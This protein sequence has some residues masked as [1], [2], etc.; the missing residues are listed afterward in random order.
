MKPLQGRSIYDPKVILDAVQ[1]LNRRDGSAN[2]SSDV[3][4]VGG[5]MLNCERGLGSEGETDEVGEPQERR[6][7][8]MGMGGCRNL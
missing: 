8:G 2:P 4:D 5:S 1:G 6:E 3:D 7:E